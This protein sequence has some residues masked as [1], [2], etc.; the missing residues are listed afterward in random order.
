MSLLERVVAAFDR[1]DVPYALVGGLAVALHGAPRGTMDVDCIIRHTEADFIAC[2]RALRSIGLV[3]RL[4]VT[5]KEVFQFRAE[6]IA[7]RNL[8]AWSFINVSNPMEVVDV[9]ITHDAATLSIVSKRFR[10]GKIRVLA[11]KDLV[12][13]KRLSGR[14]QDIEDIKM[15]EAMLEKT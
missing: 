1:D 8:I 3:P 11:L 10:L 4:P 13:M 14:P 12:A 5:A 15:L 2:E 7:R 9:I 6:Y